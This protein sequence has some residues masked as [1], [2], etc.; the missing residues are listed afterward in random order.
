MKERMKLLLIK[1]LISL[2]V[3]FP[4]SLVTSVILFGTV[5]ST[6]ITAFISFCMSFVLSLGHTLVPNDEEDTIEYHPIRFEIEKDKKQT[7]IIKKNK[8]KELEK[9][10]ES[11]IEQEEFIKIKIK[12]REKT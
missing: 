10:K 2:V 6:T 12:Q 7:I 11:L 8:I 5:A 9:F 1:F 3:I 4:I